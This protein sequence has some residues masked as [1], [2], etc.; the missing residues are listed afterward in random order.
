MNAMKTRI[1]ARHSELVITLMVDID[2]SVH[3]PTCAAKM[4]NYVKVSQCYRLYV[5]I[6]ARRRGKLDI[7]TLHF[8]FALLSRL[9]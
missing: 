4:A 9:P 7:V 3:R 5:Y 8:V 2:A 6:C 1:Y